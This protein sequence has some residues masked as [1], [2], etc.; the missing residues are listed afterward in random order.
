MTSAE[1]IAD[2]DAALASEG[3]DVVLRRGAQA[4]FTDLTVRAHVRHIRP[5]E[6]SGG[7]VAGDSMVTISPTGLDQ[8]AWMAAA[9]SVG[10]APF[11]VDRR[12]PKVGDRI[13]V[14]GR[15]RRVEHAAPI[16]MAGVLVR[17]NMQVRG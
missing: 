15:L 14:Q 16:L 3:E 13:I 8:A 17:I 11:A 12:P 1:A 9:G 6:V 4:P 7:I 5:D 2:L 10:A